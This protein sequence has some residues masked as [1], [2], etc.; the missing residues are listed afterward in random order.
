MPGKHKNRKS[1]RDLE[2]PRGTHLSEAQRIEILTLFH[3]AKWNQTR[4]AKELRLAR[5]TVQLTI[6][7]G[8]CT[9][10]KP[11]GR[12]LMLTTRKR[13]CL[14]QRATLDAFH[15]RMTYEEISQIEGISACR[16]TLTKAFEK[17]QYHRR[18]AA[19]KPLLTLSHMDRRVE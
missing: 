9:P 7:R 15:R 2:V 5:S 18:K 14:I 10:T 19:E 16:R 1:Y 11:A 3:R 8:I 17:E 4:I 13:H 6:K 12:P